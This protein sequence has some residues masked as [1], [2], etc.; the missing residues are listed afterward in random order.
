MKKRP[1]HQ[2]DMKMRQL[3]DMYPDLTEP[4]GKVEVSNAELRSTA[5]AK[6]L[7]QFYKGTK[8]FK[9]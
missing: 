6:D 9:S 3:T 8:N 5:W 7:P 2:I 4:A 1:T